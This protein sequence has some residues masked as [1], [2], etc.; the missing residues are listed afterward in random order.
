MQRGTIALALRSVP[1]DVPDIETLNLPEIIKKISMENRGL[2][3]I[4]GT[5]G[6]GKSTTLAAM[7]KYIN[8]RKK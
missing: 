5:T 8:E 1:F 2:I 7:I 3:L 4:T 6:S